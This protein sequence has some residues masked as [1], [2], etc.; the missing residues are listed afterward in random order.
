MIKNLHLENFRSHKTFDLELDHITILVGKNGAGKTNILESLSLVSAC[1]SF[2]E[3]DKKNLINYSADFSRVVCD[4]FELILAKTPR[5]SLKV[6]KK[7]V[8][9]KLADFVGHLPCVIFSP[10]TIQIITGSPSDRRRFLDIMIGQTDKEYL[11][12]LS[13]FKKIRHQRNILLQRIGS[14]QAKRGELS[15]WNNEFVQKSKIITERREAAI[16][17]INQFLS[18]YYQL[19]SDSKSDELKMKYHKNYQGNLLEKLE[20][21]LTKEISYGG[22]IFGPHRDDFS[23]NLNNLNMQNFASR[24]EMK[25]AILALKVSELN[26]IE[27]HQETLRQKGFDVE[28]PILL[29]DDI[30]SEFDPDRRSHLSELVLKYQSVITST[31]KENL[32]EEILKLAKILAIN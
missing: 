20:E 24:G 14:G 32:P 1:K 7:G 28:K 25:S 19:I 30:F 16:L 2:R 17:Y 22:T 8:P 11:L 31:E 23:V 9:I 27:N 4:D 3:E 13:N 6:R 26:Y 12:A 29:L 15:F 18:Q 5:L 10:E 21:N